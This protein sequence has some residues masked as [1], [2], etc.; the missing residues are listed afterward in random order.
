MV[1][2]R[3]RP[4]FRRRRK[5]VFRRRKFKRAFYKRRRGKTVTRRRRRPKY[6]IRTVN[7]GVQTFNP[8][9]NVSDCTKWSITDI[10]VDIRNVWIGMYEQVKFLKIT[11]KYWV[12]QTSQGYKFDKSQTSQWVHD[13]ER[14]MELRYS[15]DPDNNRMSMDSV[16]IAKRRNSKHIVGNRLLRPWYFRLRPTFTDNIH[17]DHLKIAINPWFD[18]CELFHASQPIIPLQ[19]NAYLWDF[20]SKWEHQSLACQ[21]TITVGLKGVQNYSKYI[22]PK[23][24]RTEIGAAVNDPWNTQTF[25]DSLPDAAST[26]LRQIAKEN[27]VQCCQENLGHACTH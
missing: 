4:F 22:P 13:D 20:H 25:L 14:N 5:P 2:V 27:A 21:R 10:P 15:Y 17:G 7:C 6:A 9:N 1:Y 8:K 19:R 12:I 26:R 16:N 3:R 18:T 24:S 11:F 23:T